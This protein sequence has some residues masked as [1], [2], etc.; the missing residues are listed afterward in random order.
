MRWIDRLERRYGRFAIPNLMNLIILGQA[1]V[2][3][4]IM[5]VNYAPLYLFGLER[6]GLLHGQVWRLVTFMILPTIT[7]SPLSLLLELYFYW[8]V[9]GSLARAWGDFKFQAFLLAGMAGALASCLLVGFGSASGIFLSLF[10]AYAWMWPEQQ[11]LFMFILPVKVKWLGWAAALVWAWQFLT[12]GLAGKAALLFGLAGFLLFF[13][14]ELWDWART[15]AVSYK[16][17]KDWEN[18]WK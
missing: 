4:I 6:Y 9:G 16:R 3:F 15:G 8:W 18:R 14:P 1:L 7:T 11:I 5:F 17:R 2:W 12:A 13:G 10:F